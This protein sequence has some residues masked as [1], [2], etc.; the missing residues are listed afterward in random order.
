[1]YLGKDTENVK[2]YFDE[3]LLGIIINNALLINTNIK[4]MFKKASQKLAP[5]SR[6]SNHL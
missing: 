2:F 4:E 3:K 5:L 1:M 6:L